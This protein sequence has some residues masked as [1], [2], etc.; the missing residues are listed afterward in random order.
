MK[1]IDLLYNYIMDDDN[2]RRWSL[3]TREK[4]DWTLSRSGYVLQKYEVNEFRPIDLQN[5]LSHVASRSTRVTMV[6]LVRGA[7]DYG[8]RLGIRTVP[9]HYSFRK[10]KSVPHTPWIERDVERFIHGPPV[11]SEIVAV[12]LMYYTGQRFG[13]ALK[14]RKDDITRDGISVTQQ[15]TKKKLTIPIAPE[16]D[17]ILTR[18][19]GGRSRNVYLVS[20]TLTPANQ[21]TLRRSIKKAC[22]A[23]GITYRSPHGLRHAA[24]T[25]LAE[26]GCTAREIMAVTGHASLKQVEHYTLTVDQKVLAENAMAKAWGGGQKTSRRS[27]D[28]VNSKGMLLKD[29][30]Y[31]KG[32]Y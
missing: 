28:Q 18:W 8:A 31:V 4:Y 17:R 6:S 27:P 15:K 7:M 2:R 21:D 32:V 3:S 16:L 30:G 10:P 19:V 12:A 24:A 14:M 22:E 29:G 9:F 1:L 5:V 26:S 23:R 25:K 13:D 20:G 11:R